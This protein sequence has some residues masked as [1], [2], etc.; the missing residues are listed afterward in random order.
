M[1]LNNYISVRPAEYEDIDAILRIAENNCFNPWN[2]RQFETEIGQD[3]SH[4]YFAEIDGKPAGFIDM[5]IVSL[6]AHI[7]EIAVAKDYRGRGAGRK[8]VQSCTERAEKA[9]CAE[10]TLECRK[11]NSNALS[12]YKALGFS[13]TGVRRRFYSFPEDD[14]VIMSMELREG[15]F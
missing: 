4:L 12:F 9:G 8:L 10:I 14:A 15:K 6:D 5:H 11:A 13:D 2:R 3:Y 1:T 7:N